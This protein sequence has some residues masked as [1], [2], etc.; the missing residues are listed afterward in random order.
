[1]SVEG[2]FAVAA[3]DLVK[4]GR[5]VRVAFERV[6]TDAPKLV[7]DVAADLPTIEAITNL[8]A[9]GAGALEETAF[10]VFGA[11]AAAVAAAGDATGAGGLSV[12]LDKN[13]VVDIKAA[14]DAVKKAT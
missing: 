12:T 6:G 10:N 4:V 14:I 13:L 1:M 11:V 7:K 3:R 2:V 9:P 5:A 8:V